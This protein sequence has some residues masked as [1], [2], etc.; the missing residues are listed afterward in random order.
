MVQDF[1]FSTEFS[2]EK[3]EDE[4]GCEGESYSPMLKNKASK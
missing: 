4:G 3:N 2:N 1:L